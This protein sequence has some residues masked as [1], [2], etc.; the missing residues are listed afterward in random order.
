MTLPEE[1]YNT[2]KQSKKLLEDLCDPGRTPRVPSVVRE[3]ARYIL[4]HYPTDI[5]LE[6]IAENCPDRLMASVWNYKGEANG[7]F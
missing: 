6:R 2:L 1:R 4:R 3:R 5:E 7:K